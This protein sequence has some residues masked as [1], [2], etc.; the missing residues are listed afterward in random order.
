MHWKE[1]LW[2][3]LE[4]YAKKEK[5]ELK[6]DIKNSTVDTNT[7]DLD[8]TLSGQYIGI[9]DFLYDIE[10]DD[11]LAFKILNF[12][13]T[14]TTTSE[15]SNKEEEKTQE[16]SKKAEEETSEKIYADFDKLKATF[17]IE[18]VRINFN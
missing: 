18:D 4:N 1:R 15:T 12:K 3:A 9:T 10:K 16:T 14:P 11:T 17:T 13:L 5:I 6:I 7:Y 8:I 2:I